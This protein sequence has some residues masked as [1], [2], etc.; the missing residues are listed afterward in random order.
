LKH[1]KQLEMAKKVHVILDWSEEYNEQ[2]QAGVDI[3]TEQEQL[4]T[5]KGQK[6]KVVVDDTQDEEEYM[7]GE[8]MQVDC[9]QG[10]CRYMQDTDAQKSVVDY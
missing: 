8:C 3:K 6:K 1:E 5:D 7:Q 9:M 10:D 4:G 2:E